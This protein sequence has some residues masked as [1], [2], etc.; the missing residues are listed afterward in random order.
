MDKAQ[1]EDQE[2]QR[3]NAVLLA[4]RAEIIRQRTNT[5][6][7][8][9]N[10]LPNDLQAAINEARKLEDTEVFDEAVKILE[11]QVKPEE[12]C[13]TCGKTLPMRFSRTTL[14]YITLTC[15][16]CEEAERERKLQADRERTRQMLRDH[17]LS[18]LETRGMPKKYHGATM[19]DWPTSY[20]QLIDT[21]SGLYLTG[22]RGLGKT[23]L[24]CSIM[25]EL[26]LR[27]GIHDG[28]DGVHI[29]PQQMPLFVSTPYLLMLIR[30]GFREGALETERQIIDR[31]I[32]VPILVIDDLG[33]EKTTDWVL[34]TLYTLINERYS[35]E[36]R[37]IITSNLG[38]QELGEKLGDRI[39]SRISEMC[40]VRVLKGND[41]R[42]KR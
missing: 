29:V 1:Q 36:L 33:A 34:Q 21:E 7:L 23:H 42:L 27:H 31:Y 18:Y 25:R 16:E 24:A 35:R 2:L 41:R 17:I 3:A 13:K 20:Q 10:Y 15:E 5:L 11:G 32:S 40:E 30:D 38:L 12:T 19:E 28:Q 26:V 22:N 8:V 37:T 9:R 6:E 39:S 14:R 4:K